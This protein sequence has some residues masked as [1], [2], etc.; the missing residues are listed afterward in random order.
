MRGICLSNDLINGYYLEN[1]GDK[2]AG[3]TGRQQVKRY[4]VMK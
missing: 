1:R 4:E 3:R 2:S